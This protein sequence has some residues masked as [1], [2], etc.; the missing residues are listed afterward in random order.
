MQPRKCRA[1]LVNRVFEILPLELADDKKL[2]YSS[3]SKHVPSYFRRYAKPSRAIPLG[4]ALPVS[5]P[6]RDPPKK[7]CHPK[8]AVF[9][10]KD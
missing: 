2:G 3:D 5:K 10:V 1:Q 7:G 6:F 9:M 4:I 8:E